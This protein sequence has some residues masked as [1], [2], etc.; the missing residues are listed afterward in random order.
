[1]K[2]LKKF[3]ENSVR[4]AE[5]D[6]ISGINDPFTIRHCNITLP[7]GGNC[8]FVAIDKKKWFILFM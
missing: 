3:N 7:D 4:L 2:Y 1:M 8:S 6:W 5:G